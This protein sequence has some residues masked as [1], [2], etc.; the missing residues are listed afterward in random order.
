[1]GAKEVMI[2]FRKKRY[3]YL[4]EDELRV[5]VQSL[6]R[7]KNSL[8]QQNRYT[9]CVDELIVKVLNSPVKRVRV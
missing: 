5:L 9:D 3:L 8:I 7:L 4:T 2:M 1:M 6:V